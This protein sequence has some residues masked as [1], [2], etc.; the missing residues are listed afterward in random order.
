M[1][2][3]PDSLEMASEKMK[4]KLQNSLKISFVITFPRISLLQRF[5][6][7]FS[8]FLFPF[9]FCRL[10][11]HSKSSRILFYLFLFVIFGLLVSQVEK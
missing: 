7:H 8:T 10:C 5:L 1:N 6:K 9:L 2:Y 3:R 11:S 4:M